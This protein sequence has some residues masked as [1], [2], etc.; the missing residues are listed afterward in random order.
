MHV[1]SGANADRESDDS[2]KSVP[3]YTLRDVEQ[4][5]AELVAGVEDHAIFLMDPNGIILTWNAGAERIKG[6]RAARNHRPA[7]YAFLYARCT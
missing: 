1:E 2:L 4:H 5:F 6:Y 7:I 3:D